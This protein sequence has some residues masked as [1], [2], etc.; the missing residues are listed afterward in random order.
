MYA[1]VAL[2]QLIKGVLAKRGVTDKTANSVLMFII[3][4]GFLLLTYIFMLRLQ[5]YVI[6]AEVITNSIAIGLTVLQIIVGVWV[7]KV[8]DH[9]VKTN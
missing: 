4:A 5:T 3:G 9:K 6:L 7:Y 8:L 1:M 2:T